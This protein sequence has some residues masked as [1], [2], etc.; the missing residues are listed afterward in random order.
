MPRLARVR[1][2][3]AIG[4]HLARGLFP[5]LILYQSLHLTSSELRSSPV[6]LILDRGRDC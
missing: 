5:L 1:E 2:W 3:R 6:G 4:T